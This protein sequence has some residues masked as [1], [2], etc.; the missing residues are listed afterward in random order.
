MGVVIYG[1]GA[2]AKVLYSYAKKTLDIQGFTVDRHCMTGDTDTFCQ[3]PLLPF[4]QVATTFPPEQHSM[5]VMVGFAEMNK[6]RQRKCEEAET[7]G[8]RLTS[9]VHESVQRHDDVTIGKNVVVL[10]HVSLHPGTTLGDGV[11]ISSNV[12]IGHD[13]VIGDYNWINSGVAIAGHC[14]LGPGSFWGVNACAGDGI[15][16]GAHNFIGANTLIAQ[17]TTDEEVYLSEPGMKF[18]LKSPAFLKFTGMAQ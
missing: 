6:L 3:L 18:R 14:T 15:T 11:F 5:I 2:M 12:N 13:C 8:Y 10:D 4:D 7:L 1:N 9:Y 17:N 16:L